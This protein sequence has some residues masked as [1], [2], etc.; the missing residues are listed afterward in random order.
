MPAGVRAMRSAMITGFSA[1]TSSRATSATAPESPAGGS[2]S[3]ELR[4]MQL[5]AV[6]NRVFLQL[7]VG[8]EDH[9][10]GRRSHG[11]FIGAHGGFGE[12]SQRCG[13]DRPIW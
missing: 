6:G 11:D 3:V 5:R 12:V 9:G 10:H 13:R 7:P 2:A 8:H 1:A 4:D